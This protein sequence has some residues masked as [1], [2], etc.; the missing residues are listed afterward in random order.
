[1]KSIIQKLIGVILIL[2]I[3]LYTNISIANNDYS[4]EENQIEKNN[5]EKAEIEEKKQQIEK[6]KVKTSWTT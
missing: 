4:A 1:M 3:T 2:V 5:Q 6:I